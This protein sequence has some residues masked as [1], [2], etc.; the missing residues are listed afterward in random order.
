MQ[1]VANGAQ[2]FYEPLFEPFN[3]VL[4]SNRDKVLQFCE[5]VSVWKFF[6]LKK[7]A[8]FKFLLQ[9][10]AGQTDVPDSYKKTLSEED[11][12]KGLSLVFGQIRINLDA[13]EKSLPSDPRMKEEKVASA[14][15]QAWQFIKEIMLQPAQTT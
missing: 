10:S 13:I 2:K 3:D 8:F 6:F 12:T 7:T 14:T 1:Y 9:Q 5:V 15:M 4:T 11:K